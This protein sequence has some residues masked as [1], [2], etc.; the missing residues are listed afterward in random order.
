MP[1]TGKI[2]QIIGP[3]VDVRFPEGE[4]PS[5]YT[6]LSAENIDNKKVILEV[7]QHLGNQEVRTV[8]MTSTNGL[9]RGQQA[10]STGGPIN[11]PVGPKTLG[12]LF[13]VLGE[14]IDI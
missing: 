10:V 6:A 3:V 11:V 8:A 12:R 9:K 2:T 1:N 5:I 14:P 13:N 7:A 4:L